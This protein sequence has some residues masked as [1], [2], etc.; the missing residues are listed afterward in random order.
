MDIML[1]LIMDA[2]WA[3]RNSDRTIKH[4]VNADLILENWYG[5]EKIIVIGLIYLQSTR[6][7][8]I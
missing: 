6:V 8:S 7:N 5:M 4:V 2:R 1:M 3:N